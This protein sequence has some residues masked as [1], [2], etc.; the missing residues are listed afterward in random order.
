MA[1][2]SR[3]VAGWIEHRGA[4]AAVRPTNAERTVRLPGDD[5][6]ARPD[7]VM[8]RAFTLAAPPDVV[9]PWLVQLGKSR[10]GWYLP[11]RVERFVPRGRRA[12][13]RVEARWQGLAVGDVVPDWGGA[14]ETFEVVTIEPLRTIV[15][16]SQRGATRLTWTI[17]LAAVGDDRTRV[18][19]RLRLAPLKRPWVADTL[20]ELFDAL[21]VAGMVSGLRERLDAS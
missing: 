11:R 2:W 18:H 16:W 19:L 4:F 12:T 17:A 3:R 21:T 15:Y 7:S 20:G 10:A 6:V 1:T 14:R 5:V 8:D 13:R 9:W